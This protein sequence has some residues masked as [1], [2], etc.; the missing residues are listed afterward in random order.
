[1]PV[2]LLAAA[3]NLEPE[4]I[5]TE[6]RSEISL[7]EVAKILSELPLGKE[8]MQ[9][10]HDAVSS[11]SGNGYDEEYTMKDLF[12]SPG[13]GVGEEQTKA[14]GKSYAKPMRELIKAYLESAPQTRAGSSGEDYIATLCGSAAQ[15][16][17]PYSESWTGEEELPVITFDP[18]NESSANIGYQIET[19]ASG[20]RTV[21]EVI[22]D[23][24]LARTR[25]V[26]VVNENED[27]G[28]T[29]LELLRRQHPEWGEG[30]NVVVK[31]GGGSS[32]LKMLLLKNF[33]MKRQFDSWFRGASEFFVKCGSFANFKA[34][35]EAE[36]RLYSPNITDFMIVVKRNQVGMKIPFNAILV[37]DWTDQLETVAF[38]ITEDDGGT[39]T[40]WKLEATVK[41]SSKSYGID[42]ELPYRANDDIVWRGSLS[43][44]FLQK[45]S[46][47]EQH[48]G[49]VDLTFSIE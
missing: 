36:L 48:F 32:D 29:S 28:Y 7:P 3:C 19:D 35:T 16:Y 1:M 15:I 4:E 37:S 11:S 23:E 9:E 2:L 14:S 18:G 40:S 30:G 21:K 20:K 31:S 5:R 42:I 6:T 12:S 39:R 26:W 25:P 38:M 46:G 33:C 8:Q 44:N 41:V 34:S 24:N 43:Y 47:A 22:V 13:C 49:D 17:W 10:V 27:S 45:Y